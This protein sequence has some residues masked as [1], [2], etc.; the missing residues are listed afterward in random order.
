M[1]TKEFFVST[2]MWLPG[3]FPELAHLKILP[4]V[5]SVYLEATVIAFLNRQQVYG[6]AM[7][8]KVMEV[9]NAGQ[10]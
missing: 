8:D 3:F 2:N 4:A 9:V 10:F 1:G 5:A 7:G 6:I